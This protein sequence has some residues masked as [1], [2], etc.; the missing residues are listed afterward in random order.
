[1]EV[2]SRFDYCNRAGFRARTSVT[3]GHKSIELAAVA[4]CCAQCVLWGLEAG[5]P[6]VLAALVSA[7]MC[8]AV[9]P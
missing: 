3:V 6:A 8:R 2:S 4:R 7:V 9:S 5:G 1:M